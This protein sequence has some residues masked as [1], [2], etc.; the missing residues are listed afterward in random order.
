MF[1]FSI[2]SL[3]LVVT[4]TQWRPWVSA[5]PC[6][7][8]TCIWGGSESMFWKKKPQTLGN[9]VC[10]LATYSYFT[11]PLERYLCSHPECWQLLERVQMMCRRADLFLNLSNKVFTEA[12]RVLC[13]FIPEIIQ[14]QDERLSVLPGSSQKCIIPSLAALSSL[15]CFRTPFYRT[16]AHSWYFVFRE[17][18][19]CLRITFFSH[20]TYRTTAFVSCLLPLVPNPFS[21]SVL[22]FV[23]LF[24]M[25]S[26]QRCRP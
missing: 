7:W 8:D 25:S 13:H 14:V 6:L 16:A 15:W 1:F 21:N 3:G 22:Q 2:F 24:L 19:P 12:L 20:W 23:L 10:I 4:N 26:N 5:L 9:M 11:W 18:M 17:K